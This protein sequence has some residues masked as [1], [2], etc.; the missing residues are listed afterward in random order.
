MLKPQLVVG[1]L[2]PR[3]AQRPVDRRDVVSRLTTVQWPSLL[4]A[5]SSNGGVMASA[6]WR[7]RVGSLQR[8]DRR[9]S[10]DAPDCGSRIPGSHPN[11]SRGAPRCSIIYKRILPL[12]ERRVATH[13]EAALCCQQ[14]AGQPAAARPVWHQTSQSETHHIRHPEQR[15][16]SRRVGE[17]WQASAGDAPPDRG[18]RYGRSRSGCSRS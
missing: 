11:R 7:R 13:L 16:A 15:G 17:V 1:A 8:L 10:C 5:K 2:V 9:H 12:A 3:S 6:V 18:L 4:P 14:A